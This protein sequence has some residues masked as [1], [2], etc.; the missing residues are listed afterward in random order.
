[1][2]A[3]TPAAAAGDWDRHARYYDLEHE[4]YQDDLSLWLTASPA[5]ALVVEGL[6]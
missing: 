2:T 5:C 3:G 4:D 6:D 1:M